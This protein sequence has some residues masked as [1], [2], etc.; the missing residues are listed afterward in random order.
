MRKVR[1]P[2]KRSTL[3]RGLQHAQEMARHAA[4]CTDRVLSCDKQLERDLEMVVLTLRWVLREGR[5]PIVLA[6]Q[7]L[8][9]RRL[10]AA[11]RQGAT[12]HG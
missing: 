9:K 7:A 1:P 10:E 12:A 4:R 5:E 6:F 3:R 11:A 2:L 8:Q